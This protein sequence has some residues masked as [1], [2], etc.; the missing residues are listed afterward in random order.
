ME[1]FFFLNCTSA[2]ALSARGGTEDGSEE[3][4]YIPVRPGASMFYWFY[5]TTHPDGY[6]NRPIVLWLQGGPGVAGT[7]LGN[8]LMFGPLDEHL[9]PRNSTWIQ[10][11]NV[12][13]VDNPV[14][15]GFST[16][17]EGSVVCT[18]EEISNDL[19][20]MLKTFFREHPYFQTNALHIFGQ[21]YGGKMAAA[22]AYYLHKA[23]QN[24]DIQC[25][26]E[27]VAIGNGFVSPTD[28]IQT[29]PFLLYHMSLIDDVQFSN[30]SQKASE[31]YRASQEGN[32]SFSGKEFWIL[33]NYVYSF[34]PDINVHDISDIT[35]PFLSRWNGYAD[36][37]IDDLMNGVVRKKLGI[38]PK[39]LN[40]TMFTVNTPRSAILDIDDF[41]KPVWHLLDEVLK[42][43]DIDVVVYSGQFDL[44]CSTVGALR[45][46]NRLTFDGKREFDEANRVALVNPSTKI[47]EM[48]VK[49]SG[50][51]KMYW[52][53][54]T[55]QVVPAKVPDVA[56]R[57]L[58]RILDG[59]D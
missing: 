15:V 42:S 57:M 33:W 9:R 37:D 56:L 35:T 46:M 4:G 26:L 36:M 54:N 11:A 31:I 32:W 28:I 23:I 27:G 59:L 7:G 44:L 2:L 18:V 20:T 13:F 38:I 3:W 34:V 22:L 21:S 29:W 24:S 49:S 30:L 8:F 48:F 53:L 43:S 50:H 25:T 58:N 19:I 52:V 14:G 17:D 5:R 47:P 16:V 12:L 55:G 40:Y 6:R 39:D 10:T 45:W 1:I 51:L 41:M